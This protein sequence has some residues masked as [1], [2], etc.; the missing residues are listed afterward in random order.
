MAGLIGDLLISAKA[1]TAQQAGVEIAG[2]NN[3]NVNN[4]H[5]ARQRVILGDRVVVDGN[6]GRVGS[7]VEALSIE[8]L[9]DKFLDI[10]V[11]RESSQTGLLQAQQSGLDRAET[12]L[13]ER[14]DRSTD[15]SAIGDLTHSSNGI[16]AGLNDFFN[17]FDELA[18]NPADVGTKQVL[19]QKADT[20]A[21]KFNVTDQR[22][23]TL[24]SDLTAEATVGV[25]KVN[26]LLQQIADLN[27]QIQS[28]EIGQPQAAVDLRDS[29]QAAVE[30]LSKYIDF[31][32][33]DVPNGNGQIQIVAKDAASNDVVLVDKNLVQ[34][35]G[36]ALSG[37]QITGGVGAPVLG[38]QG[39]ALKGQL[40]VRDG[41]IQQLR[42]D[43]KT[44]ADQLAAGVNAAYAPTGG[45]FFQVPPASGLLALNPTLTATTLKT[46]ATADSGANDV[47]L[48]VAD[49]G[50][51]TFATASG[52]LIDGT[53]SNFFNKTVSGLGATLSNAN[54]KLGDQ[55]LVE[56]L[57]TNRRDAVSGVSMDEEMT[58]L[59]KFQRSY[60]ASARVISVIDQM[61]DGLVNNMI[62]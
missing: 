37:S 52:A 34:G 5:H 22:L 20:L 58:D 17:T 38:L 3:A 61:L 27:G 23:G 45:T 1:L 7:G 43:L 54:T 40:S 53:I 26:S 57:M 62:R 4:P 55:Q 33:R 42:N 35:N 30:E 41:A 29:R 28:V 51:K 56:Q 8:Q 19:L 48:A 13:G 31:S 44:T 6:P 2:R 14:I 11:T 39:G 59:M 12:A 46:S 21:N 25:S 15:S 10:G 18:A 47:A 49:V 60:Q 36:I 50:R 16:S 24:Q 32:T 9:R